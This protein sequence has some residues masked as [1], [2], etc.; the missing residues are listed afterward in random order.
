M[1]ARSRE[2]WIGNLRND[3]SEDSAPS[4]DQR[5]R[6]SIRKVAEFVDDLPHP[7]GELRIDRR[8]MIDGARYGSG[9]DLRSAR[10]FANV[11][12]LGPGISQHLTIGQLTYI[13][14][15]FAHTPKERY[16]ASPTPPNSV[17]VP[18]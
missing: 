16:L 15:T 1:F 8:N 6:L 10:D 11:H 17:D 4:R 9:G 3:Q 18:P 13:K 12:A 14:Q 5:P 7:L 2:K